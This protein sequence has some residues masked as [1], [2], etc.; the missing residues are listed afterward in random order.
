M[1]NYLHI[2]CDTFSERKSLTEYVV[3]RIREEGWTSGWY[4]ELQL[5][6]RPEG[7]PAKQVSGDTHIFYQFEVKN[8]NKRK[9]AL[10]CCAF[11]E[12]I[13]SLHISAYRPALSE[14]KWTNQIQ[15]QLSI[16]PGETRLLDAFRIP[17]D[18]SYVML[19]INIHQVDSNISED[20]MLRDGEH[21][22]TYVIHSENFTPVRIKL[23]I[24]KKGPTI[25]P[26]I[27]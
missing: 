16:P 24:T 3:K 20:Y 27:L 26:L 12:K 13:E 7:I 25:I 6:Y 5:N 4:N 18:R 19:A 10:N 1:L 23:K 17:F 22:I 14:L 11:I 21:V 9:M 2:N 15:A 8:L